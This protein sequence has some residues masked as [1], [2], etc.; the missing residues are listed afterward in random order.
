MQQQQ[1]NSSHFAREKK[2]R[3]TSNEK[4]GVVAVRVAER[5]DAVTTAKEK[6]Q[7]LFIAKSK[8]TE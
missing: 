1:N 8:G 4:R 6:R 3:S 5:G 2:K 7:R